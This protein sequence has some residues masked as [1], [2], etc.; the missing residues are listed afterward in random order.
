MILVIFLDVFVN[1]ISDKNNSINPLSSSD[2]AHIPRCD[3]TLTGGLDSIM[4]AKRVK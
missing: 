4:R 2:K 3:T 1:K